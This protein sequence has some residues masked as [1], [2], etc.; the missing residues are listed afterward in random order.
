[1]FIQCNSHGRRAHLFLPK[2]E[3]IT[4]VVLHAPDML[5]YP[6]SSE[7]YSF[8]HDQGYAVLRPMRSGSGESEGV[9]S[10]QQCFTDLRDR[11]NYIQQGNYKTLINPDGSFETITLP[12]TETILIGTSFGEWIVGLMAYHSHFS[13]ILTI[14]I[15]SPMRSPHRYTNNKPRIQQAHIHRHI[16]THA[17]PRSRTVDPSFWDEILGN[18]IYEPE[19][20]IG[21]KKSLTVIHGRD[22]DV[23]PLSMGERCARDLNARLVVVNGGHTSNM[24]RKQ[25]YEALSIK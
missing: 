11:Y 4:G 16:L 2:T 25:V 18:V 13:A 15:L 23:C 7:L 14:H 12:P 6:K 20:H 24:D 9:F 22:D 3:T 17:F 1:M 5:G 19:P 21:Q 10:T 8:Y